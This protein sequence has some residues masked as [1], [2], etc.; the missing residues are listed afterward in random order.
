MSRAFVFFIMLACMV[1]ARADGRPGTVTYSDGHTLA[2]G[3]LLSPGKDL[4]LYTT[5]TTVVSLSLDQVK[6]MRFKVEKEEMRKGYYFPNPGQATQAETGDVY[7]VRYFSVEIALKD[8]RTLAGHLLTTMLYCEND[9]GTQ[10]V[11]LVAKITGEDGQKIDDL[12][13]PQDVLFDSGSSSAAGGTVIDLT[14][15][16]FV[17]KNPPV[18]FAKPDLAPLPATQMEGKQA[19]IV[20]SDHPESVL[21]SDEAADGIHVA[22]PK[23]E[24]APE[25]QKAVQEGLANMHDF[26]DSRTLLG[27]VEEESDVYS[28]VML[29]RTG[30]MVN[31]DGTPVTNGMIPWDVVILHFDYDAEARKVTLLNRTRLAVGRAHDNSPPPAVLKQ[32]ELLRDIR[33]RTSP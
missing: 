12:V 19:W 10:K 33:A 23:A 28:L 25:V 3:L 14:G 6:E 2:G 8:G 7:P 16:G 13:Y 30:A 31:G 20:A 17:S 15:A 18:I 4:R 27:S 32:P 24:A 22:W 9:D 26:Y 5:D 1:P 21:F 29:K 11:P